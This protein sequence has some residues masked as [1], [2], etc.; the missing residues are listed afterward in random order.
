MAY[1]LKFLFGQFF[2]KPSK[3]KT[4]KTIFTFLS[5]F[6]LSMS[7]L[8]ADVRPK[9]SLIIRSEDRREIR[10]VIDGRRFEPRDNFMRI[11]NI[12]AGYHRIK[13]YRQKQR[14]GAFGNFGNRYEVVYNNSVRVRQ[15]MNM[16]ISI[17]RF[18][19]ASVRESRSNGYGSGRN[20]DRWGNENDRRN[21]NRDFR[22]ERNIDDERD[23]DRDHDFNFDQ[24]RNSGDYDMND[25]D[26][27]WNDR[28]RND[29]DYDNNYGRAMSDID[30]S[31]VMESI[32]KEWFEGNKQ[33]S[34]SQVISTNFFTASQV[35]QLLQLFSFENTKL[36]LAKQAYSKTVDRNNYHIVNDVFSFSSS[37]EELS[38]YTRNIR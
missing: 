14:N 26:G 16:N 32:Q 8:A 33:K 24:S 23:W 13:I 5:S 9:S 31:R 10:V 7:L 12:D 3:T 34:A 38:R 1:A 30:F 17:D 36:E 28:N 27:D 2:I 15:G 21:D 25:R 22:N 37:K 6:L 4:M 18:G 35:R 19:R 11:R 20:N 29:R